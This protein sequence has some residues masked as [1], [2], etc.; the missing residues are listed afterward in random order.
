MQDRDL[1]RDLSRMIH[2]ELSSA[3]AKLLPGGWMQKSTWQ[4]VPPKAAAT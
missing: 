1:F 4:V 2:G 3:E